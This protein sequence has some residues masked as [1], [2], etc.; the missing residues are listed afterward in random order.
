[1][2]P[3]AKTQPVTNVDAPVEFLL[4]E[5]GI[6]APSD[7][8]A[9]NVETSEFAHLAETA[10]AVMTA[11]LAARMR[12]AF[13]DLMIVHPPLVGI[14]N[15]IEWL[16]REPRRQRARGLLV[17]GIPGSGKTAIAEL[18]QKT[19]PAAQPNCGKPRVV[20][21]SLSSARKTKD[22]L[23]RIGAATGAPVSRL[24]TTADHQLSVQETLRNMNCQL[25][26]LDESQDLQKVAEAEQ[27]RVIQ[28][29]KYLMNSLSLPVLAFS[30]LDEQN[31][32]RVDPHMQARFDV[33]EMPTWEVGED[34]GEFLAALERFIPLRNPSNLSDKGIQKE[35]VKRTGGVLMHILERIRVAAANAMVD[36]SERITKEALAQPIARPSADVL[37]PK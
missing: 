6:V 9:A 28:T 15:E 4:P 36:G 5:T 25:L 23:Y 1:M 2:Q 10:F 11:P 13:T 24:R 21:I 32:F 26:V 30:T 34:F 37:G 7:Q 27:L 31:P 14:L 16:I 18:V 17:C 3:I 20:G 8:L 35:L 22:V 29:I 19:Y 12:F 33:I